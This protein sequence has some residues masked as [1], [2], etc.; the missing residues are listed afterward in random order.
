MEE[1]WTREFDEMASA[2]PFVKSEDIPDIDLYM[3]QVLTFLERKLAPISGEANDRPVT[4]TMINNYVK[5]NVLPAPEKKK[6]TKE[7]MIY[8]LL[9]YCLK[10]LYSIDDSG[11]LLA[12]VRELTEETK[13]P[14]KEK[15]AEDG[16]K[17]EGAKQSPFLSLPEIFDLL[18][19]D[20]KEQ[21]E[22]TTKSAEEAFEKASASFRDLD[23]TEE[24]R[25][26]LQ[27]F[28][29]LMRLSLDAY[30]KKRFVEHLLTKEK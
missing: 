6:Y 9:L 18:N 2:L 10:S 22:S 20:L 19:E 1:N 11:K 25:E 21:V 3:D 13:T 4:K 14:E 27:T 26:E 15:K 24:Q 7:H 17:E 12:M 30:L 16:K 29:A 8:L 5:A 28:E 23:C